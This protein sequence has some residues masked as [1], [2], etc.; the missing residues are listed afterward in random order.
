MGDDYRSLAS[1]VT[2]GEVSSAWTFQFAELVIEVMTVLSL[3]LS[4]GF[5]NSSQLFSW[6][7]R[8]GDVFMHLRRSAGCSQAFTRV[9]QTYLYC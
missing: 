9:S 2:F 3:W 7:C 4:F 1:L 6:F 5:V 8:S